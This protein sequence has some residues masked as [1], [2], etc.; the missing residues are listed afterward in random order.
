MI[1]LIEH[2]ARGG[3]SKV[4]DDSSLPYTGLSVVQRS[5]TDLTMIEVLPHGDHLELI[6]LVRAAPRTRPAKR[7]NP[8]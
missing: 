6:E 5:I 2:V 8:S 3:F 4:V 7:T 1:V